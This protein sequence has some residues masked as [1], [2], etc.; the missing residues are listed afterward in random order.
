MAWEQF[1]TF[2]DTLASG[3]KAKLD[4]FELLVTGVEKVQ[5]RV[6]SEFADPHWYLAGNVSVMRFDPDTPLPLAEVE[7][8]EIRLGDQQMPLPGL[9]TY[10]LRFSWV[11]YLAQVNVEVYT[12]TPSDD[13]TPPDSGEGYTILSGSSYPNTQGARNRVGGEVVPAGSFQIS[14]KF[15]LQIGNLPVRI[16]LG[17]NV[18]GHFVESATNTN[19]NGTVYLTTTQPFPVFVEVQDPVTQQIT[20][21]ETRLIDP[22]G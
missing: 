8:L 9:G 11:H 2:T 14:V 13:E 20:D 7:N 19:L 15:R 4:D 18:V 10:A 5:I 1:A 22:S 3:D 16:L 6:V 17:N 12:F 21:F